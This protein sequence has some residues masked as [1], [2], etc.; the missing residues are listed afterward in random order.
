M[1]LDLCHGVDDTRLACG[2][3]L[4]EDN[5]T[6]ILVNQI[7]PRSRGVAAGCCEDFA[8]LGVWQVNELLYEGKA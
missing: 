8:G 6:E 3:K 2:V 4:Y 1:L 7:L 5:A